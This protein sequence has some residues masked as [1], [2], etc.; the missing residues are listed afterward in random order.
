MTLTLPGSS[1]KPWLAQQPPKQ[2]WST[3]KLQR[4]GSAEASTEGPSTITRCLCQCLPEPSGEGKGGGAVVPV[5][6]Y[7]VLETPKINVGK[8]QFAI[9]IQM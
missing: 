3:P 6:N 9:G 1:K 4:I 8:E 7:I 2:E 5:Y